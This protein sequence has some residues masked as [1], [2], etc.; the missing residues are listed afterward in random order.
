[1]GDDEGRA[2]HAPRSRVVAVDQLEAELRRRLTR[3]GIQELNDFSIVVEGTTDC[4]YLMKAAEITKTLH[5]VDLLALPPGVRRDDSDRIGI[6]TPTAGGG[7]R[8]GATNMVALAEAIRDFCLTMQ[9]FKGLVFVLDY[10]AAGKA[11]CKSI[12]EYDYPKDNYVLLLEP[13]RHPRVTP[14]EDMV[15]EDLLSFNIQKAFFDGGST[16]CSVEYQR[17]QMIGFRWH[18]KSK[19]LL[20]DFVC[21]RA[22]W[23]DMVEVARVIVRAR[24]L[25]GF[26][27]DL[28]LF[29]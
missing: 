14:R 20:R 13:S 28:S 25:W 12:E 10:D 6:Y 15:I 7:T 18:N 4:D 11:G 17:G 24:S 1:M 23:A 9:F 8:S 27:D 26:G 22:E 29:T 5:G 3:F 2:K 19:P 21:S 16:W